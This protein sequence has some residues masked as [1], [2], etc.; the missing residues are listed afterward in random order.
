M[1]KKPYCNDKMVQL[2]SKIN[3]N[4]INKYLNHKLVLLCNTVIKI[5][6]NYINNTFAPMCVDYVSTIKF[7]VSENT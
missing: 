4:V 7:S 2:L 6:F 1:I 5:E 3:M